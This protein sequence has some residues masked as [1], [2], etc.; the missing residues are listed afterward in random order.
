MNNEEKEL[1][2]KDLGG[3]LQYG[4]KMDV[5][6]NVHTLSGIIGNHGLEFDETFAF[7]GWSSFT[8]KP[9]IRPMSSMTEEERVE[10]GKAIQK[11]R[12]EPWGEIKSS[13]VD[14]LLLCSCRQATNFMDWLN[15]HHFDY[16]GLIDKGLALEAPEDMYNTK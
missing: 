5:D 2:L 3:R 13:G 6:G 1:L 4:V 8:F 15:S 16:R 10:M 12:I 11:D 9:Y 14:N 7:Y